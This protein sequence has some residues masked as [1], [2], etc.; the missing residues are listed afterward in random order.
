MMQQAR[1][2]AQQVGL[3]V[4]GEDRQ[5][6]LLL[7]LQLHADLGEPPGAAVGQVDDMGAAIVL[8]YGIAGWRA[9]KATR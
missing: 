1:H 5:V 8:L 9:V 4:C 3:F 2:L 6:Q 7:L